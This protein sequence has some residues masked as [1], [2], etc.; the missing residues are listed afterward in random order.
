MLLRDSGIFHAPNPLMHK[1][2][3][4]WLREK[5]RFATPALRTIVS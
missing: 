1:D 5:G 3:Y 2:L 4:Y